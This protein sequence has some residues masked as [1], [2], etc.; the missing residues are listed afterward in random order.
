MLRRFEPVLTAFF[1]ASW[2]VGLLSLFRLVELAGAFTLQLYP[3]FSLA[4]VCGW[5]FGNVYVRRASGVAPWLRRGLLLIYFLGPMGFLLFVRL[6]APLADQAAA[7][8]VPFYSWGVFGALFL[9][10]VLM[11]RTKVKRRPLRLQDRDRNDS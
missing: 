9:V 5:V 4:A 11:N 10:P 2:I 3:L 1:L 7:P 8:F 6:M